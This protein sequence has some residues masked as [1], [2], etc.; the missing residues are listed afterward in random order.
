[1]VISGW[2]GED[3]PY[4]DEVE[5]IDLKSDVADA[6]VDL[7]PF[8]ESL[9][10]ASA[11]L[12]NGMITTC[13]GVTY[14]EDSGTCRDT[15][16]QYGEG[17]WEPIGQMSVPRAYAG[18]SIINE[19]WL[20][21]GGSDDTSDIILRDGTIERGPNLPHPMKAHCQVTVDSNHVFF[22]DGHH[23]LLGDE[24]SYQGTG[25]TYLLDWNN[26]QWLLQP[27]LTTMRNH[28]AC[29][30]V[31]SFSGSSPRDMVVIA[32]DG[33]SN[34]FDLHSLSWYN[35][36]K[37]PFRQWLTSVQLFSTFLIVGGT[38]VDAGDGTSSPMDTIYR[39]DPVTRLWILHSQ[40]LGTPRAG[41]AAVAVPEDMVECS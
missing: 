32:G 37:L 23:N 35:G 25:D 4:T 9:E 34:Y 27:Q 31:K 13:G 26:Q 5:V 22:V 38:E 17:T 20:V 14:E 1:M 6:C 36:P 19:K 41:A 3:I 11:S 2:T 28:P 39:F 15:C 8:G 29:G 16:Y 33:T 12:V 30:L 40:E 10:G 24:S 21:S 18:S 7:A